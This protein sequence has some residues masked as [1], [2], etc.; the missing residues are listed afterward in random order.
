MHRGEGPLGSQL[1]NGSV[2]LIRL[3]S[4]TDERGT[5]SPIDLVAAG[6]TPVR[7]FVVTAP[8]GTIRGRHGHRKCRQLLMSVSGTIEVEV[9]CGAEIETIRLSDD[10]Q[11]QRA[12]LIEPGV[13]AEQ[14]YLTDD[15]TLLVFADT[16]YDPSDYVVEWA[17]DTVES[18]RGE[19]T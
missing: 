2:R 12:I 13:W 7:S 11:D 8:A 19:R 5:L 18:A 1:L 6:L 9:R 14:R 3:A 4:F 17:S 16:P 15:A 10:P